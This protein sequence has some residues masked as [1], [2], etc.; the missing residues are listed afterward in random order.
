MAEKKYDF[1]KYLTDA[2]QNGAGIAR[3]DEINGEK[4]QVRLCVAG[5]GNKFIKSLT[6][7]NHGEYSAWYDSF[8]TPFQKV[9]DE[10]LFD[11]FKSSKMHEKF[12]C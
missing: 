4:I 8:D 9:P 6:F 12:N 11:A 5:D 1:K 2:F 10:L 3:Y 7:A